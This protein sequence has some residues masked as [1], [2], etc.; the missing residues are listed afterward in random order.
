MVVFFLVSANALSAP[1]E[2]LQREIEGNIMNNPIRV[3]F[4]CAD[5]SSRSQIA[6][7]LLRQMGGDTFVTDSAGLFSKAVHPMAVQVMSE[8]GIDISHAVSK[9]IDALG[10]NFYDIVVKIGQESEFAGFAPSLPNNTEMYWHFDDPSID[11]SHLAFCRLRDELSRRVGLF[12]IVEKR[13]AI[14]S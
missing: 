4:L 9:D 1:F 10:G 8:A 12:T 6:E 2:K 14:A 7:A 11:G 13:S 5:N 3:L